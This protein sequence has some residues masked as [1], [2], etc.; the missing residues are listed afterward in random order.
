MYVKNLGLKSARSKDHT[1]NDIA[2]PIA[3]LREKY[4]DI[5]A[6]QLR[7]HLRNSYDIRVSR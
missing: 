3:E 5:G 7:I 4:E 6:E 1:F 2:R